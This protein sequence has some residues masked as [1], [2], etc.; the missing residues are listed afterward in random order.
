M[1]LGLWLGCSLKAARKAA[2]RTSMQMLQRTRE[3]VWGLCKHQDK[4]A[5]MATLTN[6]SRSHKPQHE[7][8]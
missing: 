2:V 6:R 1:M 3:L 8:S 5:L 7:L 4:S